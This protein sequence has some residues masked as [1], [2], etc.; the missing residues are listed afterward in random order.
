M[1][2]FRISSLA[3]ALVLIIPACQDALNPS[4]PAVSTATTLVGDG[5]VGSHMYIVRFKQDIPNTTATA[6]AL[7]AKYGG[8]LTHVYTALKGMSL[9]LPDAAVA[10]LRAEPEIIALVADG[11]A[12]FAGTQSGPTWGLDR[13]DQRSLPL[14][15][16]YTYYY[17][18][19]GVTV[20]IIDT[21]INPSH[22]DFGG[23]AS[24]GVDVTGGTGVDCNG[25]GTHVAGTVGGS[26]YG[27]AKNVQLIAVRVFPDC[28]DS[29]SWSNVIA[30][31]DWVTNNRAPASVANASIGG[32]LNTEVNAHVANS[33]AAGVTYA[34]AAGNCTVD[35]SGQCVQGPW[36]ACTRSPSSTSGAITVG[37]T[38]V[39]DRFAYFANY[40]SCVA[41]NAPGVGITS[42]YIG[43]N[44]ATAVFDGTSQASPHVAGAAALFLQ[45]NPGSTPAQVKSALVG[46]ASYGPITGLPG[47]TPNLLLFTLPALPTSISGPSQM[48][49]GNTCYYNAS[50]SGGTA[51]YTYTWSWTTSGGGSAGGYS[52]NN[53]TFV[54]VAQTSA[55]YTINLKVLA[56]DANGAEGTFTK[57]VSVN[58]YI[59]SCSP[60]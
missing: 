42:D 37:A 15:N 51:P 47:G 9:E 52:P 41:L 29:T 3:S 39:N 5:R 4:V 14:S 11:I 31:I 18:G 58:P 54:L 24:I 6:Q 26:A 43:S 21:G 12:R 55:T 23:R 45:A 44:T 17:D 13:V 60:Y 48:A 2:M 20:Y 27:V 8:H 53:G 25:H 36:D 16:S 56:T 22:A 32:T 33:I 46:Q 7:A 50:A 34:I 40:G 38:D 35:Y 1:K 10:A 49:P 28:G 59:S 30:G 19:T 57:N